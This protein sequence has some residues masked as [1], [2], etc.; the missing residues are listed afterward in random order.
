DIGAVGVQRQAGDDVADRELVVGGGQAVACLAISARLTDVF[1]RRP[2][3]NERTETS[4]PATSVRRAPTVHRSRGRTE[5]GSNWYQ[6]MAF[7]WL[8]LSMSLSA[9]SY[10]VHTSANSS[11]ARGHDES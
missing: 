11:G 8:I 2:V 6:R 3:S 1:P 5:Y 9:T 10:L 4:W 7:S